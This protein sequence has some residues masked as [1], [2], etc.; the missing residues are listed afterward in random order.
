MR[1]LAA[2]VFP[3]VD[4]LGIWSVGV[5]PL[6]PKGGGSLGCVRKATWTWRLSPSAVA[7]ARPVQL[8]LGRP[9]RGMARRAQGRRRRGERA[10]GTGC[11][12]ALSSLPAL[13]PVGAPLWAGAL[14]E[15]G[16][17][18]AARRP[19]YERGCGAELRERL[20]LGRSCANGRNGDR[21]AHSHGACV[22]HT[23]HLWEGGQDA[24]GRPRAPGSCVWV[25]CTH[26]VTLLGACRTGAASWTLHFGGPSSSTAR[27]A[28]LVSIG[29]GVTR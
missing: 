11:T 18:G 8:E 25:G 6:E 3:V 1:A 12:W 4:P 26:Q 16:V 17:S 21:R 27:K 13:R 29:V 20:V 23:A 15:V 9:P 24:E 2:V 5:G 10:G 19:R 28:D 14:E 7:D 22:R